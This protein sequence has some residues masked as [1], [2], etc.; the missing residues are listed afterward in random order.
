MQQTSVKA[1]RVRIMG[2]KN[3]GLETFLLEKKM[4]FLLCFLFVCLFVVFCWWWVF[5]L[6]KQLFYWSTTGS[7]SKLLSRKSNSIMIIPI[8]FVKRNSCLYSVCFNNV[9][10][11]IR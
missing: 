11:N 9:S 1:I 6:S 10:L 7:S 3:V 8:C 4:L 5:F 2:A